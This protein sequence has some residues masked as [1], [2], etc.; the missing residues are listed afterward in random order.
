MS[1]AQVFKRAVLFDA[2]ALRGATAV[3]ARGYAAEKKS[4][5]GL[6]DRQQADARNRQLEREKRKRD[7]KKKLQMAR[8]AAKK[9]QVTPVLMDVPTAC[10]YFRAAEVGQALSS[11]TI[12]LTVKFVAPRNI[13]AIRGSVKLPTDV[14]REKVAVFTTSGELKE[15]ALAA[16][17]TYVGGE[18]LVKQVQENSITFDKAFATPDALSLL[19]PVQRT[20][21]QRGLMPS[22]R[23]GTVTTEIAEA[24]EAARGLMDFK[25]ADNHISVN[26]GRPSLS[27]SEIENNIKAFMAAFRRSVDVASGKQKPVLQEV[28]LHSTRSPGISILA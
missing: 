23:R 11:T 16:G 4:Q 21:G 3:Q 26:I 18:E 22:A 14:S 7:E 6:N 12:S 13:Q 1:L 27:D 20:L 25:A 28:I 5:S 9:V 19:K 2:G 8:A 10:R 17:A 15:Q 24:L